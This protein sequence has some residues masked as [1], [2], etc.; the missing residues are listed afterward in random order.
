MKILILAGGTGTRLWPLSRKNHPKQI[1]PFIGQETLLGATV[2]RMS[3][4]FKAEDIFLSTNQDQL[5]LVKKALGNLIKPGHYI[6]EPEKRDTAPAIGLACAIL[7]KKYPH[8]VLA[9][10]NSDHYVKNEKEF[11]RVLAQAGKTVQQNPDH[12]VMLGLKPLSP[13]TGYGYIKL[14]RQTGVIGKDKIYRVA[15]FKEKPDL[16][17]AQKYL[18]SGLYLWNPAYFVFKIETMLA[19]FQS[20]LPKDYNLL[21]KI[22]NQPGRL[23]KYF[24]QLEKISID[25]GIMERAKK[26]LCLPAFLQWADVGHFKTIYEILAGAKTKNIVK[27]KYVSILGNG[28]F[29]HNETDQLIATAGVN[30][31]IIVNTKD[32]LL[33]C[34]KSQAQAV[35]QLTQAIAAQGFAKY[36]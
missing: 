6:I 26:M 11:L 4:S 13:E 29:V 15:S 18:A 9:V 35:K 3:K 2:N 8:E 19:H 28:N 32:A 30:D 36:L 5:P 20:Y 10:I 34:P 22:K 1:S 16:K 33:I 23:K 14:G 24:G 17:T 21:M 25:Y 12:L 31:F 7:S 27:G